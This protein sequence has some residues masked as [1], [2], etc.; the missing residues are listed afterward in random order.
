MCGAAQLTE[1]QHLVH[2]TTKKSSTEARISHYSESVP[3]ISL[4]YATLSNDLSSKPWNKKQTPRAWETRMA[5]KKVRWEI[6]GDL[7]FQIISPQTTPFHL[8]SACG[9]PQIAMRTGIKCLP[10]RSLHGP[11]MDH[12]ALACNR[13]VCVRRDLVLSKAHCMDHA[14]LACYRAVCVR[15][16]LVLSK[17][18][19][20]D[21]A[22]HLHATAVCIDPPSTNHCRIVRHVLVPSTDDCRVGRHDP[23]LILR[24]L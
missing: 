8:P 1:I 17:A 15:Q 12:A 13:A 10:Q 6:I 5:E 9:R 11:C 18:H 24:W 21:H 7:D 16:D 20:M 4:A 3:E 19:C 2:N 23:I 14:A 22:A